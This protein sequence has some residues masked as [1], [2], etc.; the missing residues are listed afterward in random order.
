LQQDRSQRLVFAMAGHS[1]N[2]KPGTNANG[3]TKV[4]GN[5]KAEQNSVAPN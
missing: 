5:K 1:L 2:V 3:K 4:E